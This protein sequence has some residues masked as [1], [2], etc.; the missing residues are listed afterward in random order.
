LP[1]GLPLQIMTR[2]D[3]A[4]EAAIA[5]PHYDISSKG[6][7]DKSYSKFGRL[8]HIVYTAQLQLMPRW[9]SGKSHE[10]LMLLSQIMW[11]QFPDETLIFC[12]T[13]G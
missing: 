1:I 6:R 10:K 7:Y 8:Q 4:P 3:V 11:V 12:S 2:D 9:C 13:W 5:L